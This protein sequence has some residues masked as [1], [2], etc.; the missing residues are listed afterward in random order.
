MMKHTFKVG[1]R[2]EVLSTINKGKV[3]KV[4]CFSPMGASIV[5]VSFKNWER[6]HSCGMSAETMFSGWHY[7]TD[8][9]ELTNKPLTD[10]K[11]F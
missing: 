1:D 2:V 5:S 3:G 11:E 9:L 8:Q 7:C 10:F 6:G 4:C